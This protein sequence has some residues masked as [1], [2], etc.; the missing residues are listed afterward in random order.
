MV[1]SVWKINGHKMCWQCRKWVK[2]CKKR[3]LEPS[4]GGRSSV[5]KAD[6][7]EYPTNSVDCGLESSHLSP[8]FSFRARRTADR[9][10][11]SVCQQFAD[12][13]SRER[14]R[15]NKG[16]SKKHCLRPR[17][18]IH[19]APLLRAKIS[20]CFAFLIEPH[21]LTQPQNNDDGD[22]S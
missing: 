16:R 17:R 3:S 4:S 14:L 10:T 19:R 9:A 13:I 5:R 7:I 11:T 22:C 6:T 12:Q 21:L 1:R 18:D 8:S 20:W 2:T 15:T